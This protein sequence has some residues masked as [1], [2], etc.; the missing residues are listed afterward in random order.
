MTAPEEAPRTIEG[1]PVPDGAK[2]KDPG[3]IDQT[4]QFDID[5]AGVVTNLTKI[6]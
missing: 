1:F 2:V 4:W 6:L 3:A 5:T